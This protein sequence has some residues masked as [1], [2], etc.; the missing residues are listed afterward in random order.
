MNDHLTQIDDGNLTPEE[1]EAY[2]QG[3]QERAIASSRKR[4]AEGEAGEL[5]EQ[6]YQAFT[7]YKEYLARNYAAKNDSEY[8]EAVSQQLYE[9][10]CENLQK[11]DRAERCSYMRPNGQLCGSPRM[12][13]RK[14]C[15]A[16]ARI[17][18]LKPKTM[19]LRL[20]S[21]EDANGIQMA[22]MTLM[23][24]LIDDTVDQKKAGLMAYLLQTAASNVGRVDIGA[25]ED[26]AGDP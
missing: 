18:E 10:L 23:Q 7:A 2:D 19:A 20:P 17:V 22:I 16:H 24:W 15:Y 9:K 6:L 13:G 14:L 8:V 25:Y 12:K 21:L 11:A 26:L 1:Q 3:I 4:W 5:C